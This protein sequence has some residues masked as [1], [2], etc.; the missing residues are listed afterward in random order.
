MA[1]SRCSADGVDRAQVSDWQPDAAFST[2]M[3]SH[4]HVPR[5]TSCAAWTADMCPAHSTSFT[6]QTF[7]LSFLGFF[8]SPPGQWA[9]QN[10]AYCGEKYWGRGGSCMRTNCAERAAADPDFCAMRM[11]GCSRTCNC[12]L[13]GAGGNVTLW[14][15]ADVGARRRLRRPP[16][17]AGA[18]D[19]PGGRH[20]PPA[21]A[22][23][24]R[25][26]GRGVVGSHDVERRPACRA[27]RRDRRRAQRR[28]RRPRLPVLEQRRH[29]PRTIRRP[30]ALVVGQSVG[31]GSEAR[32]V[33]LHDQ[34]RR[35]PPT[36]GGEGGEG[37]ACRR[38][39]RLRRGRR[40]RRFNGVLPGLPPPRRLR[41]RD[42]P[43]RRPE[44]GGPRQLP[45][46]L[47]APPARHPR[48]QRLLPDQ[49]GREGPLDVR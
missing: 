1:K 24:A 16:A 36:R 33:R 49:I 8:L 4:L 19:D 5:A 31:R 44:P 27:P 9:C 32:R 42:R 3:E 17:D 26:L 40:Q 38:V 23:A 46:H 41:R 29:L 37:E 35:R 14:T 25:L 34:H 18:H 7:F 22:V 43:R 12:A 2:A 10:N 21:A 47:A 15:P 20:G 28:D 30:V 11:T 39:A 48:H 45:P 13:R 6:T